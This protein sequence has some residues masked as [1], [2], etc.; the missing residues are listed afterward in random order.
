MNCVD[1]DGPA[2]TE[3]RCADCLEEVRETPD[4]QPTGDRA[5]WPPCPFCGRPASPRPG[6]QRKWCLYCRDEYIAAQSA[7][8]DTPARTCPVCR[9][10]FMPPRQA[11]PRRTYCSADCQRRRHRPSHRV[12][13]LRKCHACQAEF[14][15]RVGGRRYCDACSFRQQCEQCAGPVKS[16]DRRVRFC[17]PG[18][19]A[20]SRAARHPDCAEASCEKPSLRRGF[21]KHHARMRFPSPSDLAHARKRNQMK[22]H[23]RRGRVRAPDA[24]QIDRD[25]V[26]DRDGWKCGICRRKVDRTK[27]Y[28][29]PRSPSVDHVIPQAEGGPHTYANVRIAHLS[30]NVARS[31]GGGGEQ[32]A[33]IG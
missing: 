4:W 19:S 30:C 2:V 3:Q 28:P 11:G 29:H 31:D 14:V 32:L 33:L 27:A 5:H 24:E 18:C 8:L 16:R 22:N 13:N 6:R 9:R 26:G 7:R 15:N 10:Q 21:C 20:A 25:V 12:G 1:C 17:S 23:A